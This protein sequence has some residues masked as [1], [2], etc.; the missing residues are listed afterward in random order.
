MRRF[1]RSPLTWAIVA[2]V[3]VV[4][5]LLFVAWSAIRSAGRPGVAVPVIAAP[6]G[7]AVEDGSPLPE[8]P[9]IT[10]QGAT[11]PLPGL[12]VNSSFWRTRLAELNR[13]QAVLAELE[14]RLVH[15]AMN[16]VRDYVEGVVLPAIRRAERAL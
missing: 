13:D 6:E 5:S 2:E 1:I 12:N 10:G 3:V 14:W 16:A 11:G 4:G 9:A 15:A 8:I 7:G